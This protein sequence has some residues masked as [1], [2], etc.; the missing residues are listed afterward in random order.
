MAQNMIFSEPQRM[1]EMMEFGTT[2]GV[3]AQPFTW[4]QGGARLTPEQLAMQQ[5][6]ALSKQQ[7]DYSPVSNIFQGLGRVADNVTGALDEKSL[8]KEALA[9][10]GDRQNS[11]AALLAPSPE[12]GPQTSSIAAALASTDP[13]LQSVGKMAYERAN[14]KPTQPNEFQ[15]YLLASGVQPGTPEWQRQNSLRAQASYDPIVNVTLPTGVFA[16]PRSMLPSS[17]APQTQ[18]GPQPGAVMDGYRFKGGDPGN[19]ANWEAVR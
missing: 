3:P 7:G 19:Q 15:Q 1:P 12:S 11:I 17:G 16:G 6:L 2:F 5:K 4:G 10:A 14:P 9:Q 13:A 18:S 8:N